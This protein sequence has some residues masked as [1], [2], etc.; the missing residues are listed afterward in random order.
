MP[1]HPSTKEKKIEKYNLKQILQVIKDIYA[2]DGF[3][4]SWGVQVVY[5]SVFIAAFKKRIKHIKQFIKS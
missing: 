5:E 4:D 3:E 1:N 2:V